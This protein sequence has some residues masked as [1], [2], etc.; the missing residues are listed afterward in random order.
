MSSSIN[1][2]GGYSPP[3]FQAQVGGGNGQKPP[4][5]AIT[6]KLVALGGTPQ[7]SKEQDAAALSVLQARKQPTDYS[8]FGSQQAGVASFGEAPSVY[9]VG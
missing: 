6:Q 1:A 3:P 5:D 2:V 9:A 4:M 8:A 7:G